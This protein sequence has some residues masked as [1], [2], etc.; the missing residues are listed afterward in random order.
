MYHGDGNLDVVLGVGDEPPLLRV[1]LRYRHDGVLR[2]YGDEH[3]HYGE[4][5]C[6]HAYAYDERMELVHLPAAIEERDYRDSVAMAHRVP[7]VAD[8][9]TWMSS[10]ECV[11]C[12]LS[13]S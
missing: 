8:E 5:C 6:R 7:E 12:H 2:P 4:H 10:S 13:L 3:E 1:A 11:V 9:P